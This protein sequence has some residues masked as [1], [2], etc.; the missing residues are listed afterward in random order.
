MRT[1]RLYIA[2]PMT[3]VPEFNYPLF[4]RV[5]AK[6]VT[7]GYVVINPARNVP[8]VPEPRWSDYMRMSVAQVASVDG[9]AVL[10]GWQ[11]SAGATLEVKLAND[12]GIEHRGAGNGGGTNGHRRERE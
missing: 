12:L 4:N 2:G 9:I 6:L 3:G 5:Q 1:P 8:P 7:A 10:P 11:D